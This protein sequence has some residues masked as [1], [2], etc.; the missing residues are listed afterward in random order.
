MTSPSQS[1]ATRNL[2]LDS[3]QRLFARK[4]LD[5]TT[6]KEIGAESGLNPALLYYYF[7][8]KEELY[9]AVARILAQ[10]FYRFKGAM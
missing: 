1:Q 2:I 6:I 10:V 8:S 5:P 4:G 3:A 7:E 9:R